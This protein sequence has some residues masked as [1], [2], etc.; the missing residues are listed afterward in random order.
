MSQRGD[1]GGLALE[2]KLRGGPRLAAEQ[3]ATFDLVLQ[4]LGTAERT[5]PSLELNTFSPLVRVFDAD[6][7]RLVQARPLEAEHR[8]VGEM[9]EPGPTAPQMVTLPAGGA[10]KT[11]V[12]LWRF[13]DPLPR[14]RYTF[15]V[16]H[17]AGDVDVTSPRV[18]FE[19][20][21]AR[22]ASCATSYDS[23]ARVTSLLGWAADV[24][25]VGARA[26]ARLSAFGRHAVPQKGA[27][28]LG[29]GPIAIAHRGVD[30]SSAWAGW[31][32]LVAPGGVELVRHTFTVERWRSGAIDVGIAAPRLVP[33]FPDRGHALVLATGVDAAGQGRLAGGV[34][35]SG[36]SA[37]RAAWQLPLGA[38]PEHTACLFA[39][40]GP[41]TLLLSSDDGRESRVALLD[42][43]EG[44]AVVQ[45]E[46]VVRAS[47]GRVRA[48]V[49]AI[50]R[51]G[52][53]GFVLYEGDRQRHDHG[54]LVFIATDRSEP[55]V[56]ALAPVPGWPAIAAP[57]GARP[58]EAS[59]VALE[60]GV[61]GTAWLALVDERGRLYGG[62]LPAGLAALREEGTSRC[63][64]IAALREHGTISCFTER[65]ALFHASM[66]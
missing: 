6:G 59:E 63:P 54:S 66:Y 55:R 49:A 56:E 37:P 24:E 62:A 61:D 26:L 15:E 19:V 16:S 42:V 11:F 46:S 27:T 3:A 43:D 8:V 17:R 12:E 33:R 22:V 53:P 32:A 45:A 31:V 35:A 5:V 38:V 36:A 64:H 1:G 41:I 58:A 13:T 47:P 39:Q 50:T 25:G 51:R 9:G 52:A 14:G 40:A 21:D 44:G 18:E 28:P 20:V 30:G 34:V 10:Q 57:G 48:V 23:A 4:N 2:A 60:I 29:A 65:G 7:Q